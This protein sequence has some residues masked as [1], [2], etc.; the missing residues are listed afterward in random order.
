MGTVI[1]LRGNVLILFTITFES[2]H[3][4]NLKHATFLDSIID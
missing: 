3:G 4:T 1:Q 2:I